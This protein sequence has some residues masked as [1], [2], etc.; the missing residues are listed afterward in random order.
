MSDREPMLAYRLSMDPMSPPVSPSVYSNAPTTTCCSV[1]SHDLQILE[2]WLI[3]CNTLAVT[4][5]RDLWGDI[6]QWLDSGSAA[7]VFELDTESK[8]KSNETKEPHPAT[9]DQAAPGPTMF[10]R[11]QLKKL[12][13]AR[14]NTLDD[15]M[16][17]IGLEDVKKQDAT[18][19]AIGVKDVGEVGDDEEEHSAVCVLLQHLVDMLPA[20]F[21]L[22]KC[23]L[24]GPPHRRRIPRYRVFVL[25]ASCILT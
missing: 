16:G 22:D 4:G 7:P 8:T 5:Q 21:K 3:V 10:E 19:D 9:E 15:F 12:E 11:E 24:C 6:W 13:G 20:V 17:V 14:C 25:E 18:V 2:T 23:A 1:M